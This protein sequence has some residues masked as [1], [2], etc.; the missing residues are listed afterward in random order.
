MGQEN[1]APRKIDKT[2]PFTAANAWAFDLF[3]APYWLIWDSQLLRPLQNTV[4]R[5]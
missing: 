1:Q 2:M 4:V 3:I 5:R